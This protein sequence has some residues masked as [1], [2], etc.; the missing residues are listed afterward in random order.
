[1]SKKS[2]RYI[3]VCPTTGDR[4]C[5]DMKWRSFANFGDYPECVKIY[6]TQGWAVKAAVR[7]TRPIGSNDPVRTTKMIILNEGDAMNASGQVKRSDEKS[8]KHV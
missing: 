1:M 6:R 5:K 2:R 8:F 4:L 7:R 3:V